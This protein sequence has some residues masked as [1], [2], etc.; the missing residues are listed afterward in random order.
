MCTLEVGGDQDATLVLISPPLPRQPLRLINTYQILKNKGLKGHQITSLSSLIMGVGLV[1]ICVFYHRN[2]LRFVPCAGTIFLHF[3]A[4]RILPLFHF[5]IH[6]NIP[7]Q[8]Q[9]FNQMIFSGC[10]TIWIYLSTSFKNL[11][12]HI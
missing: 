6:L 10:R 12:F 7:V 1:L 3:R 8:I 4:G 2:S 9:R 5:Y 11:G